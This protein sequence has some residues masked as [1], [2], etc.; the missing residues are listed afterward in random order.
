M[1]AGQESCRRRG[2]PLPLVIPDCARAWRM[3]AAKLFEHNALSPHSS[4]RLLSSRGSN[5]P[6]EFLCGIA[7]EPQ[8]Q[9]HAS[10]FVHAG[11]AEVS[12]T[13]PIKPL[14]E[15]PNVAG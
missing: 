3:L 6:G 5:L 10:G 11:L 1:P 12:T 13:P 15:N 2:C 4:T 9:Q 14:V 8:V 7:T